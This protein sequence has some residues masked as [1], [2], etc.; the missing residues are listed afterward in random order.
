MAVL[1]VFLSTLCDWS[2][3]LSLGEVGLA[4]FLAPSERQASN[5][6]KYAAAVIDASPTLAELVTDRTK[7]TLTLSCQTVLEVQAAS[8]RRSRG[9]TAISIVLDECSF[10]DSSDEGANNDAEIMTALK[11]SLATTGGPMLL[12]SSPSTMEGITYKLYKRHYGPQGD[13]RMLVVQTDTRSLNPRLSQAIIDRAFENDATAADAEFGGS[14]R[15]LSTAFLERSIVEKVVDQVEARI[16]LPEVQY[17]GFADPSGGTGRDSF[18]V[19]IGHKHVDQGREIAVLDALF[20]YRPP[21]DPDLVVKQ[22][23]DALKEWGVSEIVADNY[24][25]AWPVSAFAKHGITLT[26]ASLSRSEIYVHVVPLFTSGRVKLLNNQRMIDQLC[27]LRRKVGPSG[28]E[29]V[30]HPR[31]QHDDL[32]N[33]ACGVLWR[34]S[35]SGPMSSADAWCTYM[36]RDLARLGTDFDDVRPSQRPEFGWTFGDGR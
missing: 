8:W 28:R 27:A 20:E 13:A 31:N 26:H 12:T 30:D 34:L 17:L 9:G 18:T 21:F 19:A 36:E 22:A 35:P 11:P 29:I 24:A 32:S 6:F 4:L 7:D 10:F 3:V 33:S 1:C 23:A 25:A 16:R 15:Q 2:S 14:F 5:V